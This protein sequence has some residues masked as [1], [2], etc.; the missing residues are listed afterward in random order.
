MSRNPKSPA[1]TR[2]QAIPA[3]IRERSIVLVGLMGS[4]KSTIGRRLAQRLGMRFADADDEIE[5]AAGMTISDIFARFGEAHFRDGERRVIQRLLT[6]KPLVLATGGGAFIND[7]TRALILESSL[8]IWLDAD[9]PT[10]VD[11][12]ARRSHRPLLKDRD[13]GEVLRELAAVR[14]P[15][16]AEAH[17]RVSSASTPHEHTVR[18]IMEAIATCKP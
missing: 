14:N 2:S 11:R 13:P 3:S 9:I 7:D 18:A 10:L 15:I 6:G 1:T 5:R 12:V 16:Y 4:G 8:C 17:L